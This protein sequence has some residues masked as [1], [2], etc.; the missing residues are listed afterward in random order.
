[1]ATSSKQRWR[2][3]R[4]A[5]IRQVP[6]EI[7][8]V[9]TEPL[10]PDPAVLNAAE[11]LNLEAE[12]WRFDPDGPW[13]GIS[14]R[15]LDEAWSFACGHLDHEIGGLCFGSIFTAE[16][17]E[18][19]L[20]HVEAMLPARQALTGYTFVTF[21]YEAW[22]RLLEYQQK[23]FPELRL[24]GWYHSHPGF[25]VFLS[26]MD[27]FIHDH[28]FAA[29]WQVAVV[30]EPVQRKVGLFAR[31]KSGALLSEVFAWDSP[32]LPEQSA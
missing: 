8:I 25:G 31:A 28:F 24:V 26:P 3:F 20:I 5:A 21:T 29:L 17:D 27:R 18:K 10:Y 2:H 15:V 11:L 19:C 9:G 14:K 22:Q 6:V 30:L 12:W 13:V 4:R 23:N 16:A 32:L 1:M 7:E